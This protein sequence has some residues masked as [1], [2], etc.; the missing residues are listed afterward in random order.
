MLPLPWPSSGPIHIGYNQI[1]FPL[2]QVNLYSGELF[3][4]RI[5]GTRPV[6]IWDIGGNTLQ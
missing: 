6:P 1:L 2:P 5:A 3:D 4:L